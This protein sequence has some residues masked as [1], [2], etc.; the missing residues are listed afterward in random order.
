MK[1]TEMIREQK[2]KTAV[3][4]FA[5]LAA[6]ACQKNMTNE[7][8]SEEGDSHS[9][10]TNGT[11]VE[12]TDIVSRSTVALY[13][14][15]PS[16]QSKTAMR[17]FCTGTLIDSTHVLT[18]A[19]CFADAAQDLGITEEQL[20]D[21]SLVVFG[22][23]LVKDSTDK[24]VETRSLK[25]VIIHDKYYVGSVQKATQEAMYDVALIQLS[26][27]APATAVSAK[28]GLDAHLQAGTNVVLAG[29]GL[30]GQFLAIFPIE[31]K[32]LMKVTVKID[33]PKLSETQFSYKKIDSKGSCSGDSGGPAY[34]VNADG[35]LTVVGITSWGDSSCRQMG[36]YTN[37][38]SP[39]IGQWITE[40]VSALQ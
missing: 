22:T 7:V 13:L 8:I 33:N 27:P 31:A 12:K 36:A 26:Q 40:A 5:F 37:V 2:V 29:F 18:A 25:N 9:F 24:S 35:S 19:H 30:V 10:I 28:L 6:T 21:S 16:K 38:A 17:N 23:P 1:L 4:L 15:S 34:I 3:L 39:L 20:R 11:K 32:Q 14:K